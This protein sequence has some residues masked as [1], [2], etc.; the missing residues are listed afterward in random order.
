[1]AIVIPNLVHDMHSGVNQVEKG[2]TWLREHL[3]DYRLWAR[4]HDSLLIVTFDENSAMKA[5][6][7]DPAVCGKRANRIATVIDGAHVEHRA[8]GYVIGAGVTHVNLLR[9]LEW[10][11][12]ASPSGAQAPKAVDAGIGEDPITEI[13]DLP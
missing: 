13:F 9:T 4:T 5:G 7:T 12:G 6:Y 2:D 3:D 1:V 10:L 8:D 11:F